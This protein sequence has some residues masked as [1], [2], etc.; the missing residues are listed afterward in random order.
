[1]RPLLHGG[2][3]QIRGWRARE[4]AG[5]GGVVDRQRILAIACDNMAVEVLPGTDH[6]KTLMPVHQ[7]A[8][9]EVGAYLIE[10]FVTE[11]LVSDGL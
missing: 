9:V 4:R 3:G 5:C 6:P 2:L 7:H 10:N 11:N 1:M 8:L